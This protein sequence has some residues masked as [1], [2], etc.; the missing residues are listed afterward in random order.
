MSDGGNWWEQTFGEVQPQDRSLWLADQLNRER[1]MREALRKEHDSLVNRIERAKA[2]IKD[3]FVISLCAALGAGILA[4]FARHRGWDLAL[5]IGL[6]LFIGYLIG[7]DVERR[8][9]RI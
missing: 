6:I 5:G 2:G 7:R 4:M 1:E 8:I 3:V 9:D